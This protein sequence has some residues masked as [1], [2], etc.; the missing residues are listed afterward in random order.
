M[1]IVIVKTSALGDIVQAFDVLDYLHARFPDAQIDWIVEESLA[2]LV[3]AHPLIR[4]TIPLN[5]RGLKKIGRSWIKIFSQIKNLRSESYDLLFD[6]QGNCKSGIVSFLC[7]AKSKIGFGWKSV[8]ERPNMLAMDIRI[9]VPKQMNIRLHYLQLIQKYFSDE[10]SVQ[11]DGVRFH[12]SE[13]EKN[14]VAAIVSKAKTAPMKIMVCPGSKWANK[15][16]SLESLAGFLRKIKADFNPSFFL[17]WGAESEK[18]LCDQLQ[19]HLSDSFVID[20]LPIP[21]W[22]NLMNE[23]DL[24]IAVDSSALHLCG[25][26]KT[27]SFS[28]FGPTSPVIFKPLG[29]R[30]FALQGSCPYNRV[31]PKACPALRTCPTGACLKSLTP[32]QLYTPFISWWNQIYGN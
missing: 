16:L 12:I 2:S 17:M 18:A 29:P 5:M 23:M 25:T 9:D 4:R 8:R 24:V 21:A 7:R 26:T 28:L 1:R 14:G 19:T 3:S 30:H 13:Q 22:Q 6:L 10:S 11:V 15:Q 32:D 27:P 31:F 20:R